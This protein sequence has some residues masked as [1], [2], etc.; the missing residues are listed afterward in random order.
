MWFSLILLAAFH[1]LLLLP[2]LRAYPFIVP[3]RVG[4]VPM[5]VLT[6]VARWWSRIYWIYS[7][8]CRRGM[9]VD[10]YKETRL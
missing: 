8:G 6:S 9:D 10:S 1:G 5:Y 7:G 2:V 4:P 3:F